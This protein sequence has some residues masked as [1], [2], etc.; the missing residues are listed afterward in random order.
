MIQVAS[1]LD[2]M[3][4]GEV[5]KG[6]KIA[7]ETLN[8]GRIGIGA[9]MVGLAQGVFDLAH[10]YTHQ[11]KQFGKRIADFQVRQCHLCC[12]HVSLHATVPTH[13][14]T[15]TRL[16]HTHTHLHHITRSTLPHRCSTDTGWHAGDAIPGCAGADGH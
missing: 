12:P 6:Y 10:E 3:V 7:I 2:S 9:Q 13:S 16:L 15:T 4:L 11:R 8:E 1:G 14:P 5:G